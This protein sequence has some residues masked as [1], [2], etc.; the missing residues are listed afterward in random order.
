M[1]PFTVF[2]QEGMAGDIRLRLIR[3]EAHLKTV[4][5][6]VAQLAVENRFQPVVIASAVGD[7]ET[8]KGF[9]GQF[10]VPSTGRASV[11][12]PEVLTLLKGI[13]DRMNRG[14]LKFED[15]LAACYGQE[16][17]AARHGAATDQPRDTVQASVHDAVRN[18]LLEHIQ[19]LAAAGLVTA[20]DL[21]LIA[22]HIDALS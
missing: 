15:L 5:L 3:N 7:M 18:S 16:M 8:I 14:A 2:I 4:A 9:L 21:R 22:A 1:K 17:A 19:A 11:Y 20:E 6:Q 10:R 12:R 13:E